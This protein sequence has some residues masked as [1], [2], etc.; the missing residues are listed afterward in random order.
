V[1]LMGGMSAR[2][3]GPDAQG[4]WSGDEPC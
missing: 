1:E 4:S 2:R 3:A